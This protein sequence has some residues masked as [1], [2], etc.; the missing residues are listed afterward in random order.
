MALVKLVVQGAKRK[1]LLLA[2]ANKRT[3]TSA[4]S[5]RSIA[6]GQASALVTL[7]QPRL[8]I[9]MQPC[10]L[11]RLPLRAEHDVP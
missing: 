9:G 5:K 2:C 7:R 1:N 8:S 3:T 11:Y 10:A 6:N 4:Q